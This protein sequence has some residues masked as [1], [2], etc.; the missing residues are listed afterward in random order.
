MYTM[1]ERRTI[2]RA[3]IQETIQRAQSEFFPKMQRAPGFIGFYLV[4]D[5]ENGINTA[6]NVWES[7]AHAEAFIPEAASWLQTLDELGHTLQ[8]TNRGETMVDLTPQ[9]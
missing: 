8:S 3:R 7:K 5:E 1:V 6:I 9:T 4:T 2:N